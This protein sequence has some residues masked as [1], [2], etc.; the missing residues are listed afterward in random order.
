MKNLRQIVIDATTCNIQQVE[1]FASYGTTYLDP[2]YLKSLVTVSISGD[3]TVFS[4][5]VYEL[6]HLCKEVDV[7]VETGKVQGVF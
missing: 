6:C 7:D 3:P 5:R 4:E 1:A 2:T